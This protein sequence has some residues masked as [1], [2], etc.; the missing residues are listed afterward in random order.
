MNDPAKTFSQNDEE[1]RGKRVSLEKAPGGLKKLEGVPFTRTAKVGVEINWENKFL[2]L[3][4][5]PKASRI[6]S[7]T[8]QSTLS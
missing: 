8:P 7:K 3:A 2:T 1:N 4:L 6:L 5:K